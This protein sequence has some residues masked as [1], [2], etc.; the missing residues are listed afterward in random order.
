[1]I[2]QSIRTKLKFK[3]DT[4][5]AKTRK[6]LLGKH[7]FAILC[8]TS[9]GFFAVDPED[10]GVGGFL[11]KYGEYGADEL[12]VIDEFIKPDSRVLIVGAHIGSLTIPISKKVKE[13][14]AIEANPNTF[15]LLQ[16]AI[17]LNHASNVKASHIA[18]SDRREELP[19]LMSRANSGGSKRVP[20]KYMDWY[21]YDNPKTIRVPAH[22]LDEYLQDTFDVVIMDIEGSEVFAL[23][24]MP[25][26][27]S[28]ASMLQVEFLPHH[29]KNVSGVSVS[30]FLAPI[31]IYFD[32]LLIPSRNMTV[33]KPD[34]LNVLQSMFDKDEGD[35]G[36]IFTK[37]K[38]SGN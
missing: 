23:K 33:E 38:P 8:E 26:I 36:I 10:L 32:R 29:L 31:E 12:K 34:F 25:Q 30:E 24:G 37:F 9:N 11:L 13:V 16:A 28:K 27:L 4:L 5:L 1:M 3:F 18:A 6:R 7:G 2:C 17:A 15:R 22:P 14:V 20:K 35:N 19:F 21:Y